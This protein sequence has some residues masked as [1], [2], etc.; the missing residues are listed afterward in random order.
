MLC[1]E[2]FLEHLVML[3]HFCCFLL[4]FVV[5]VV[6]C[7]STLQTLYFDG[8]FHLKRYLKFLVIFLHQQKINTFILI[9]GSSFY[10]LY[11]NLVK[12]VAPIEMNNCVCNI[13]K[14]INRHHP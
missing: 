9:L 1:L 13:F 11:L 10:F 2:A 6:P 3:A 12:S 7:I 8:L 5:S 4:Y 14:Q